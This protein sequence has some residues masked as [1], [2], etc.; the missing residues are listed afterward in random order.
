MLTQHSAVVS[1]IV[2]LSCA[3]ISHLLGSLV[4]LGYQ[5]RGEY[6]AAKRIKSK[7]VWDEIVA[8][9]IISKK[10]A[11]ISVILVIL[12]VG[13]G[14]PVLWLS[15]DTQVNRFRY[16][17]DIVTEVNISSRSD[18]VSTFVP[19]EQQCAGLSTCNPLYAPM[20]DVAL[21]G[22]DLQANGAQLAVNSS[23]KSVRGVMALDDY[24]DYSINLTD[25]AATVDCGNAD[26]KVMN[27]VANLTSEANF[28]LGPMMALIG[29]CSIAMNGGSSTISAETYTM[30]LAVGNSCNTI[31]ASD[32]VAIAITRGGGAKKGLVCTPATMMYYV[33]N[34]TEAGTTMVGR[35]IVDNVYKYV[36]CAGDYNGVTF[37]SMIK[38]ILYLNVSDQVAGNLS[39]IRNTDYEYWNMCTNQTLD[40]IYHNQDYAAM[41]NGG[42]DVVL[43]DQEYLLTYA[44]EL[45]ACNTLNT[46]S[47]NYAQM[48]T[49]GRT[50][51]S[52]IGA[53][54]TYNVNDA[55]I[56][57][58]AVALVLDVLVNIVV[59]RRF[60]RYVGRF[61][62]DSG[63]QE[64][65]EKDTPIIQMGS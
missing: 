49:Q 36:A 28:R 13:L 43:K 52:I 1:L 21:I 26:I 14:A 16:N 38:N 58:T 57:C 47:D 17:S 30:G 64:E 20:A 53:S 27:G 63:M 10:V 18:R 24:I 15:V 9:D 44:R 32:G 39:S 45:E 4:A 7:E 5:I 12:V 40:V 60:K 29:D 2:T 54:V 31:V 34:N 65:P 56:V 33:A 61:S 3:I 23:D 55:I 22:S 6:I 50:T 62:N 35:A 11:S 51:I 46:L 59:S 19:I 37:C 41:S 25:V 48:V 8:E 42:P